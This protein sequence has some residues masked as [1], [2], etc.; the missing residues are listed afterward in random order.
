MPLSIFAMIDSVMRAVVDPVRVASGP[1]RFLPIRAALNLRCVGSR[2]QGTSRPTACYISAR[3]KRSVTPNAGGALS[4]RNVMEWFNQKTS[5]AGVQVAN[6]I[7]AL[8]AVIV[9]LLIYSAMHSPP[10]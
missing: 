6:W 10:I 4:G 5:I 3:W 8:G 7:I 2:R 1:G 9:I